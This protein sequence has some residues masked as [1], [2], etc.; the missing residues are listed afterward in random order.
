MN[1]ARTVVVLL[2]TDVHPFERL[3]GWADEWARTH[4]DDDVVVQHG[5]T[6]APETARGVAILP[7][8]QLAELIARADAVVCHGGPGT[9]A[10]ARRGG[11]QPVLVPR[12]PGRG[13][14]VDGHQERFA[15]W[16]DEHGLACVVTDVARLDELVGQG[17]RAPVET[18]DVVAQTAERVGREVERLLRPDATSR[19][20]VLYIAGAGRSGSTLVERVLGQVPGVVVLGEVHHLWERGVA[21]DELCGCGA[22][23]ASCPFWSEVGR[24]AFG[25][26]QDDDVRRVAALA[27]AV[28]RHRRVPATLVRGRHGHRRRGLLDYTDYY[29]RIYDAAREV[30]GAR[31]VVDSGKHPTL[32][33]CLARDPRIDLRILHLVRDPIGVSYSW[34]KSVQ[35]PEARTAEDEYMTQYTPALSSLLWSLTTVEAELLRTTRAPIARLRYEDFVADPRDTLVAAWRQLGLEPDG[36]DVVSPRMELAANHTVAG[37]PVRF[38]VGT[39]ELRTD[40]EWRRSMPRRDKLTVAALTGPLRTAMGYGVD[41]GERP[42]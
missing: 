10:D 32:A 18:A 34:A 23:F 42:A 40:E 15:R 17:T 2:G 39:V 9:L 13:E 11:H 38:K 1:G 31:L 25:G 4:P 3:V 20:P 19:G 8:A 30:T 41:L 22:P 12:A 7:P 36:L 26:W 29:R 16:V 33:H 14:H 24:L 35:R 5:Y 6:R 28:D 27:D 21:R 37:N